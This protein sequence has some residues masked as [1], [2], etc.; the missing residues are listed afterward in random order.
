[1]SE[2]LNVLQNG[3]IQSD[4]ASGEVVVLP[5]EG[6]K[7]GDAIKIS[8]V[9]EEH[10]GSYTI[11]AIGAR[12]LILNGIIDDSC[13]KYLSEAGET[14]K[15]LRSIPKMDFVIE[16]GNRLWGCYYGIG[17]DGKVI[18]EIYASALGDP[19]NWY[20]YAGISTD[21]WT[22]T[23]G[24]D[25]PF[26][27]AIQ[28]GGYP[29]FFKENTIIRVYGSAPSSF[30]TAIY[31]YRGVAKG[32]HKSLAICDEVLY[33]LSTD[34][35]MAYNGSVPRK[36]SDALGN[37]HYRDGVAGSIGSKYY[38]SCSDSAA[39]AHLFV[40]DAR[41]GV[42]HREDSL[43]AEQFLRRKTELYILTEGRVITAAGEGEEIEF[44]AVTGEWGLSNPYRKHFNNFI[45]RA[46]VP[47]G[48]KLSVFVSYDGG[49]F[50]SV[51]T[52]YGVGH[53]VQQIKVTPVR[54]DRVRLKI[55]GCGNTKIVSIYRE[56][57]EGGKD[58]L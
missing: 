9:S 51:S 45:I 38:L 17:E 7:E 1:M 3:K 25:G 5:F 15:I 58:V 47:F 11:A 26:T 22:A 50:L 2:V 31:N 29:L 18:N 13:E 28:Y 41:Y 21:S 27:G 12:G 56:I 40:F 54:C 6:F 16:S 30:S 43:R 39:N 44:E 23:V 52:Y 53:S 20:R 57:R 19:T 35:V 33:Y 55:K 46:I 10:D 37:E 32:S 4:K 42:W 36:E 8:G 48:E 14:V 49:E 24:A 34:G